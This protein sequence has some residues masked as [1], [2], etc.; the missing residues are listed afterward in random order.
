METALTRLQLAELLLEHF[1]EE[2]A[3]AMEHLDLAIGKFRDMEM[4]PS[5]EHALRHM[6]VLGA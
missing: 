4:Q 5:L 3:E 1:P 6:E 2:R